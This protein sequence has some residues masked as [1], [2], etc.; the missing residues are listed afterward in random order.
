MSNRFNTILGKVLISLWVLYV[1]IGYLIY[2]PYYIKSV[3]ESPYFG[4]LLTLVLIGAVLAFVFSKFKWGIRPYV[5]YLVMLL[6][7]MIP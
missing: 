1:V 3:S 7:M 6:F 2:R 4:V 5:A